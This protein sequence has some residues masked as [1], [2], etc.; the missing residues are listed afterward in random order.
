MGADPGT[1]GAFL[2]IALHPSAGL[3]LHVSFI[4]CKSNISVPEFIGAVFAKTSPKHARFQQFYQIYKFL[5][6]AF[7]YQCLHRRTASRGSFCKSHISMPEF[8][9]PVFAQNKPKTLVFTH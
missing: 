6:I 3:F 4:F 1:E 7:W 5:Y 2:G 9:D 8:I